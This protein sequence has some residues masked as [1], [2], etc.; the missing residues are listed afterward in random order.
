[1]N[2]FSWVNP[3]LFYRFLARQVD[4]T[5]LFFIFLAL[6]DLIPEVKEFTDQYPQ[7]IFHLGILFTWNFL[8]AAILLKVLIN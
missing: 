6:K 7:I 2:I 8:E 5:L 3:K 1:M 4:Y